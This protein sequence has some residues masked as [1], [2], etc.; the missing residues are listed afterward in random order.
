[1]NLC[2]L[3]RD[4]EGTIVLDNLAVKMQVF[5]KSRALGNYSGWGFDQPYDILSVTNVPE[6][7]VCAIWMSQ[8]MCFTLTLIKPM[9]FFLRSLLWITLYFDMIIVWFERLFCVFFHRIVLYKTLCVDIV[10]CAITLHSTACKVHQ[11]GINYVQ[12][13]FE[14]CGQGYA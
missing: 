7:G 9:S 4:L 6:C 12:H 3:T 11:S 5:Y 8:S 10:L 14:C 1:M 2:P 13:S